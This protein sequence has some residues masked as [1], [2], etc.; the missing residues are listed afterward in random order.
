MGFMLSLSDIIYNN[1]KEFYYE[2][3]E[4]Q[5]CGIMDFVHSYLEYDMESL[6]IRDNGDQYFILV[7]DLVNKNMK[8]IEIN[9]EGNGDM[10]SWELT[11]KIYDVAFV[12]INSQLETLDLSAISLDSV[13]SIV[14]IKKDNEWNYFVPTFDFIDSINNVD[15]FLIHKIS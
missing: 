1:V 11:F 8:I 9:C 4:E 6:M 14:Q 13:N 3:S 15:L 12:Y 7:K 2:N 10:H 5:N